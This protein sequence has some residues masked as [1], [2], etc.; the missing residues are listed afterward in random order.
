[1]EQL[2]KLRDDMG[3]THVILWFNFGWLMHRE[4][5]DQ[6]KLFRDEVMPH[7]AEEKTAALA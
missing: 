1:V 7:F 3:C 2:K 4:V 6:M 5:T